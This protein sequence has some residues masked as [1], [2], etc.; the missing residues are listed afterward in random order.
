MDEE[1]KVKFTIDMGDAKK[2]VASLKE[3]LKSTEKMQITPKLGNIGRDMNKVFDNI[4]KQSNQV[5]KNL[6]WSKEKKGEFFNFFKSLENQ[7]YSSL[8]GMEKKYAN[9]SKQ[10]SLMQQ[11]RSDLRE[12]AQSKNSE[13]KELKAELEKEMAEKN[14]RTGT[15]E[16]LAKMKKEY[17]NVT[18]Q[19]GQY[20]KGAQ[21]AKKRGDET[22]YESWLRDI[23]KLKAYRDQISEKMDNFEVGGLYS[24][25]EQNGKTKGWNDLIQMKKEYDKMTSLLIKARK[26][27]QTAQAKGDTADYESWLRDIEKIKAYRDEIGE[28]MSSFNPEQ[29]YTP[30]SED[31][32]KISQL[33]ARLEEVTKEAQEYEKALAKAEENPAFEEKAQ[34]LR[35]IGEAYKQVI[36]DLQ[37]NLTDGDFKSEDFQKLNHEADNLNKNLKRSGQE[38]SANTT[39]T[40]K[41]QKLMARLKSRMM[42]SFVGLINPMN[43]IRN[44]W[45]GFLSQNKDVA[46]TFKV[47]SQNLIK[48]FEPAMRKI[49]DWFFKI[50]QYVN[51]FTKSWFNVDLFDK[52]VLSS[53]KTKKNLGEMKK[54]TASFDELNVFNDDTVTVMDTTGLPEVN[55]AGLQKWANNEGKWIGK[56]LNWALE[57]PLQTLGIVLGAKFVGGLIGKGVSSLLGKGLSKLFGGSAVEG[58]ASAGGATVGSIFGKT[59]YTGMSG[60][61]VTVGKLLGGIT[62]LAGGTA[63]AISQ[64]ADAGGNWQ[65]LT[66]GTKAAKVGIAGLGSAAAGLGAVMLGASGPVGWAVAG[67]VALTAFT[68]GMAQTQDG[69]GSVKKETEKLAEAQNNA[70]IA[71]QN[72][73]AAIY[74]AGVTM[75][76]LEQLEQQTGL[77]GKALAEQVDSG[78]LSVE[79]MT[80]AQLQ[81]YSAYL[82][83]QKAIEQL[84]QTVQ[85]KKEADHQAVLQTL[86]VEAANAISAKSY[87]N[88]KEKVVQAWKEG[89]ISAEEAGDILS[90]T[91]ANADSETQRTFG[92]SIPTEIQAAFKPEKYISGWNRFG[93]NFKNMMNDLGKWFSDKWTGIKNWWNGL[94]N[95]NKI[96]EPNMPS[97]SSEDMAPGFKVASYDVGTNYVPNDQ[98][99]MVH[100]G[101]AIVPAKYNNASYMSG[102]S[103]SQMQQTIAAMNGEISALRS[104]IQQGI[105][106]SGTFIQRGNDLYATVEKAKNKRGNQPISNAAFAR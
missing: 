70:A 95:K 51:V 79:N 82:Q 9:L 37:G 27:A 25:T 57:N 63:V 97:V 104:L 26:G 94:W 39:L 75:S 58:A 35:D 8:R 105:P 13:A 78:R 96:P 3:D 90:R 101:E 18:S 66:L 64:A 44:L 5:E 83:N 11:K 16:D 52:S 33:Q 68:I 29:A 80:S 56:A 86:Q 31:Y 46:N 62:L 6:F 7:A 45:S 23:D 22:D 15:W 20:S 87:D 65:D 103:N 102:G 47:I 19:I 17:D 74:N 69:I 14:I 88:L 55:T 93:T 100:R 2:Q 34:E 85:D 99:A 21:E 41:W 77:S 60:Q 92:E 1:F 72:Y 30:E 54:L 53:E 38:L 59:L 48:V 10:L 89:S 98:L 43:I 106:V 24:P 12:K 76:N 71:Q 73:E 49:A 32:D 36:L 84:K 50:M 91:L 28:K 4:R 42:F 61:A 67:V 81:V 40:E